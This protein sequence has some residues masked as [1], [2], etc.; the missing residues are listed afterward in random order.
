[1]ITLTEYS[2]RPVGVF[3][4]GKAG[5]A[6]VAA[7][8]AGGAEVYAWDDSEAS[9]NALHKKFRKAKLLPIAQW[10]WGQMPCLVLS[11]GVPLTHP[12][13]H[14]VVRLAQTHNCP[15]VGDIELLY[16]ACPEATFVGITGT[17]GKSTTTSL[18]AHI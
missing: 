13:P 15:V 6:T 4:V 1:M 7:L 3:G 10:P 5:E 12:G 11:P 18:I 17:N 16:K 9:R 8:L 14:P 2:G